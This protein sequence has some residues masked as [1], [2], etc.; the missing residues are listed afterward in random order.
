MHR[1]QFFYSFIFIAIFF[2]VAPCYAQN[3]IV[4]PDL[5]RM[6]DNKKINMFNRNMTMLTDPQHKNGLHLDEKEGMGMAW[7]EGVHFA[8]GSI[9]FDVRGKDIMQQSFVGVAFH[10]VNDST[11]EAVYFRPFNFRSPDTVRRS[12]CVQYI[13]LPVYDWPKLRDEHP[14]KYEQAISPAPEPNDWL[15]VKITVSGMQVS[16]YVNGNT[17]PSLVVTSLNTRKDGKIGFWT[18]NNSGGDFANLKIVEE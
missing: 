15:H 16:V 1:V 3:K 5:V 8:S 12:H 6:A 9:E 14:N 11:L 10:G 13:S 4:I 18:G 7:L 17:N 2:A